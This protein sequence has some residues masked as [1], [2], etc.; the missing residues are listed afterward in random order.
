MNKHKPKIPN[1]AGLVSTICGSLLMGLVVPLAASAV[2]ASKVNPCPGIY[3]E[4]PYNSTRLV[5]QGCRPNTATQR[6]QTGGMPNRAVPTDQKVFTEP[7]T[8]APPSSGCYSTTF[9]RNS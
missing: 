7:L 9:T 2:P 3:Y 5:P 8:P 6:L 4:E 1:S